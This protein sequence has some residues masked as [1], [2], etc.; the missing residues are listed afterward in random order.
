MLFII[1]NGFRN[2]LRFEPF[3]SVC[4]ALPDKIKN[5]LMLQRFI[6]FLIYMISNTIYLIIVVYQF[7][8][9]ESLSKILKQV[10]LFQLKLAN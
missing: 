1:W 2:F 6:A 10:I 7:E 3:D 4:I 9:Q 8:K 5:Q